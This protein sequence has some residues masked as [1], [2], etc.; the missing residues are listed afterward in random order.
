MEKENK[1]T[2]GRRGERK[3]MVAA[4]KNMCQDKDDDNNNYVELSDDEENEEDE[5][6]RKTL[7]DEKCN[8]VKVEIENKNEMVTRDKKLKCKAI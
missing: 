3:R 8:D 4:Q 1:R 6:F 7:N 2:R 5:E